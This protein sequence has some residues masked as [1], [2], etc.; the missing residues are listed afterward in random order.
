MADRVALGEMLGVNGGAGH[1]ITSANVP[2]S[3]RK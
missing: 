3:L 2:S 1:Q